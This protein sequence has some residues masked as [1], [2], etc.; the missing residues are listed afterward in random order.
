MG[1]ADGRETEKPKVS[2]W[3]AKRRL[4]MVDLPEPEGPEMTMGRCFEVAG[5]GLSVPGS[6]RVEVGRMAGEGEVLVGAIAMRLASVLALV[7]FK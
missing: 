4:R 5:C 3:S 2:G 6:F 7:N 1:G